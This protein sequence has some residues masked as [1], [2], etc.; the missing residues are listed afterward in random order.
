MYTSC[1]FHSSNLTQ[2]R[3][4]VLAAGC[5]EQLGVDVTDVRVQDDHERYFRLMEPQFAPDEWTRITARPSPS[6][7]MVRHNYYFI[8]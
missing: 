5:Y 2:G 6:T 1:R 3:Y 4:A 8:S 7:Q